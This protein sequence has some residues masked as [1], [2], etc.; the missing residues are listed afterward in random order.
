MI[1]TRR[2]FDKAI[3][4]GGIRIT[5]WK[6]WNGNT[7]RAYIPA[8][9]KGGWNFNQVWVNGQRATRARI[10][11]SGFYRVAGFPDGGSKARYNAPSKHFQFE[12]GQFN[13]GWKNLK[14]VEVIVYHF[15][16]DSHMK[17]DSVDNIKNIVT[18]QNQSGK[19]FTDDY[20]E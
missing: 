16:T 11:N 15:W 19:R 13:P 9:K 10:P 20:T 5:G 7:W 17:V 18:F 3:I 6:K 1:I 4:S 12:P 8:V 2:F 14:D